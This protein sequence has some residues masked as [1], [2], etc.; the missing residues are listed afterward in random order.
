MKER[1]L[2]LRQEITKLTD[3]FE[4]LPISYREKLDQ[5][6]IEYSALEDKITSDD[7]L[8]IDAKFADWYVLYTE[9]ETVSTIMLPEG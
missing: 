6:R 8:W 7:K 1:A 3:M 5:Y 2:F 4:H 9:Y